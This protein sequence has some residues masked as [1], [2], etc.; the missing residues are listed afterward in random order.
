MLA[1]LLLPPLPPPHPRRSLAS[2]DVDANDDPRAVVVEDVTR[3]RRYWEDGIPLSLYYYYFE[4]WKRETKKGATTP[5]KHM[6]IHT[7]L[8]SCATFIFAQT[9][10]RL[11]KRSAH[12]FQFSRRK[13]RDIA[14]SRDRTPHNKREFSKTSEHSCFLSLSFLLSFGGTRTYALTRKSAR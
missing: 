5:K 3:S 12:F 1:V 6:Q 9:K 7:V 10:K 13:N 8:K 2:Y 11:K 4:V 14:T